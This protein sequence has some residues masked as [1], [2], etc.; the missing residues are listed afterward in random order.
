M[1]VNMA[2]N[3]TYQSEIQ[4]ALTREVEQLNESLGNQRPK[5]LSKRAP[6]SEPIQKMVDQVEFLE[7]LQW[8]VQEN[9]EILR[10]VDSVVGNQVK[11]T[12]KRQSRLA[13]VYAILSLI[14]GWLLS[15][16]G[17]PENIAHLFS[18]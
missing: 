18:H 4:K 7:E 8:R 1:G 17:T 14:A 12:E 6:L 2:T 9:P 13:L 15:L 11:L 3:R 16:L 10:F 5:G